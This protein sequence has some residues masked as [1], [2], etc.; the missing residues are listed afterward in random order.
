MA[1]TALR[2]TSTLEACADCHANHV[3]C[4]V[5]TACSSVELLLTHYMESLSPENMTLKI[6]ESL[7]DIKA[8]MSG[9]SSD[10]SYLRKRVDDLWSKVDEI[11]R[12]K[13]NG[14]HAP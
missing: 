4:G 6:L 2:N 10:V 8:S 5:I 11:E 7:G 13:P 9:I 14:K 1:V 12:N 3:S